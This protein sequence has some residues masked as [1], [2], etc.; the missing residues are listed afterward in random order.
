MGARGR[1]LFPQETQEPF[2]E[3]KRSTARRAAESQEFSWMASSPWCSFA[4]LWSVSDDMLTQASPTMQGN[5]DK[6]RQP[7]AGAASLYAPG[8]ASKGGRR[9]DLRLEP[10]LAP[11]G[12]AAGCVLR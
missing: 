6:S 7:P 11:A 9:G 3:R 12:C 10:A 1:P 5:A 4:E 2:V 8:W